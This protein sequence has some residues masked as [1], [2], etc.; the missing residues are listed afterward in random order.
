LSQFIPFFCSSFRSLCEDPVPGKNPTCSVTFFLEVGDSLPFFPMGFFDPTHCTTTICSESFFFFFIWP[1]VSKVLYPL[2][3]PPFYTFFPQPRSLP[4]K[5]YFYAPTWAVALSA[6][7]AFGPHGAVKFVSP[8]PHPPTLDAIGPSVST[9]GCSSYSFWFHPLVRTTPLPPFYFF[10]SFVSRQPRTAGVNFQGASPFSFFSPTT[11]GLSIR[12]PL[13]FFF[14]SLANF[15]RWDCTLA[16]FFFAPFP[17]QACSM[18]FPLLPPL[19]PPPSVGRT[20]GILECWKRSHAVCSIF[21]PILLYFSTIPSPVFVL[22]S[23]FPLTS[24]RLCVLRPLRTIS[25]R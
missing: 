24:Y 8:P 5:G 14:F 16:H 10:F 25:L 11:D 7:N 22:V 13:F 4:P 9:Q 6:R 17:L 2:L 3:G 15:F 18:T 12:F 1:N 23:F 19:P 21:L 20:F